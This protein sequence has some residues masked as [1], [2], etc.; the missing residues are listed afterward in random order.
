M[1]PVTIANFVTSSP[2]LDCV[3]LVSMREFYV[4][5]DLSPDHPVAVEVISGEE[6]LLD[7]RIR[8]DRR[9]LERLLHEDFEEVG[10]S[11]RTYDRAQ[12]IEQLTSEPVD[13]SS[14]VQL[15]EPRLRQVS[16]VLVLLRW[17]TG[18][19]NPSQRT[20]LWVHSAH[21][22]QLLFHQGTRQPVITASIEGSARFEPEVQAFVRPLRRSD[23]P[24]VLEAF[25]SAPD[26]ARQG[27]VKSLVE[28]EN[29]VQHL[30]EEAS[31]QVPLAIVQ[32]T[33][34]VGLVAA[35]VDTGNR[36]AWVWYWMHAAH[37]GGGLTSR[38]LAAL[39]DELFLNHRI[40]RLELGLRVNNP[41]S[42]MVAERCG[43]V[44][45]GRER[46]KFLINGERIDVLN[47][48]RLATDPSP[49][50]TALTFRRAA[51]DH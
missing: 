45:E 39:A 46:G 13:E 28:A 16:D 3:L 5:E 27:E 22:W 34:L 44:L 17:T 40:H 10:A 4:P 14:T 31:H 23:A 50:I 24:Q 19:A 37:R 36:N 12:I 29:Y 26:M 6:Q 43:F 33:G 42:K 32:G 49:A 38:A 47:Y 30:L 48:A 7:R 8:R 21:G 41:A 25:R 51:Q 9:E 2:G 18:A 15:L 20:S 1:P 11:G 35:S